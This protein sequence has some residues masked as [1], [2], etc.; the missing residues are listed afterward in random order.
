M[1]RANPIAWE[2]ARKSQQYG[3][4]SRVST[5]D[6]GRDDREITMTTTTHGLRAQVD[7]SS[8]HVPAPR[9]MSQSV[10]STREHTEHTTQKRSDDS[11]AA[12]TAAAAEPATPQVWQ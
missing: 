8:M 10:N 5:H 7:E 1:P 12:A 4:T 11:A 9:R 6:L 3:I 2:L